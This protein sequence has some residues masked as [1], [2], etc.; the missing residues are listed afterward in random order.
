MGPIS[1]YHIQI[2]EQHIREGM[3]KDE[4]IRISGG[5]TPTEPL[6]LAFEDH[7]QQQA[8][9]V[10]YTGYGWKTQH[11]RRRCNRSKSFHRQS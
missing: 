11:S 10:Q 8:N 6:E 1:I 3:S 4:F 7:F 9:T 2:T 5:H